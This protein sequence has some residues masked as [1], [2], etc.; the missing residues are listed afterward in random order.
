MKNLEPE[1]SRMILE[2]FVRFWGVKEV[3]GTS[4]KREL[5]EGRIAKIHVSMI[6]TVKYIDK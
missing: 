4:L 6:D 3:S 1:W 2:G 5:V